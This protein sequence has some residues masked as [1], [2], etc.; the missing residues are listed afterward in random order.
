[1]KRELWDIL[2][3]DDSPHDRADRREMLVRGSARRYQFTE[4]ATGAAAIAKV[5]EAQDHQ[6]ACVLL[7]YELADMTAEEALSGLCDGGDSPLC[8]VVVRGLDSAN[9]ARMLRAGAQDYVGKNWTTPESLNRAVENAVERFALL[10]ERR[11]IKE[12]IRLERERLELALTS[13]AMGVYELNLVNMSY[14]WSAEVYAVYGLDA[15]SFTPTLAAVEALVHPDDLPHVTGKL[16]DSI[17]SHE[18]FLHEF[19]FLHADGSYHWAANRGQTEYDAAGRGIRHFGVTMDVTARKRVEL[20][21]NRAVIAAEDANRAKSDFL[22]S[23]SHELR[24]PLGAILGF[25][26]LLDSGSPPAAPAQK[27]SIDQILKAGWYLLDLINEILDLALVE[28]GKLSLSLEAVELSEVLSECGTMLGPLA[29]SRNI[30]MSFARIDSPWSVYAD[31]TRFK[32]ILV[33]L[34]SNAIKYNTSGGSVEVEC[35]LVGAQR[36]RVAIRDGGD[37]LAPERLSELF[38][39]FNRLGQEEGSETG[40]GIGLV[41]CKRL[42]EL[43]GGAIGMESTLGKGSV[44]WIELDLAAAIHKMVVPQ[45]AVHEVDR[46]EVTGQDV[47][48]LLYVEDNPANLLLV[49]A[50]VSSRP[51]IRMFSARDGIVGVEMAQNI[52]PDAILMDINLPGIS[53]I[54]A[55]ILLKADPATAHIPIVALS[56]NAMPREIQKGLAAGF[57]RYLTK[58]FKVDELLKTLDDALNIAKPRRLQLAVEEQPVD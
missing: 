2:L 43:M 20:D 13:G 28:S 33:N 30:S 12:A 34:L 32:Q 3:V 31:R 36:L 25:A 16:K 35:K 29:H 48:T 57:F 41:M 15:D 27:R 38:Q 10:L 45:L 50:L 8:P 1:M 23:M 46:A 47:R 53:G 5:L 11:Q 39:P 22:A 14:W 26:Q 52:R 24:T 4:V 37:G 7:D 21:L 42:V 56:A 58:P 55:L 54:Q 49:E 44:F 51:E 40:T 6:F 18:P 17:E 9:S 19:R